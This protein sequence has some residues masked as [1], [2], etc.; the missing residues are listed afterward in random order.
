ML[1]KILV[2]NSC[3]I[4]KIYYCKHFGLDSLLKNINNNWHMYDFNKTSSKRQMRK[5]LRPNTVLN[6]ANALKTL[7]RMFCCVTS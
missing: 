1:K 2:P 7:C 6:L 4:E 5:L 3:Y